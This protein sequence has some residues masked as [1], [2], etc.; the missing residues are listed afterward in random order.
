MATKA[1][2]A[3]VR[4]AN[5]WEDGIDSAAR[6]ES[7][8]TVSGIVGDLA[9]RL[10]GGY[11]ISRQ[12]QSRLNYSVAQYV[13]DQQGP[14]DAASAVDMTMNQAS[15][16]LV[17]KRLARAVA[18]RDPRVFGK[19]RAFNGT[20]NGSRAIRV[21][22]YE[23]GP[24]RGKSGVYVATPDHLWH[25]HLEIHRA[26]VNDWRILK[27]ILDVILGKEA[28][29]ADAATVKPPVKLAIHQQAPVK[30]GVRH[31]AVVVLQ[32]ALNVI[33]S[34]NLP[35]DGVF[36]VRTLA[37]VKKLQRLGGFKQSTTVT[38]ELWEYAAA[39]YHLKQKTEAGA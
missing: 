7:A 6:R 24:S 11:H 19:I 33:F 23:Y 8:A 36:G 3:T 20:T 21:E 10:E 27:G 1:Y 37:Y 39:R 29:K 28:V 16:I 5:E 22:C 12:D 35:V 4:F 38:R 34:T 25:V 13:K 26:Y 30:F 31:A 18:A 32:R 14:A 9:H 17:T 2:P 15:M